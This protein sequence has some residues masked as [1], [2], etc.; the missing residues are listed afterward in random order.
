M[1]PELT[2]IVDWFFRILMVL[3]SVVFGLLMGRFKKLEET[4]EK[5]SGLITNLSID[6]PTKYVSKPDFERALDGLFTTLRRIEDKV[7]ELAKRTVNL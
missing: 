6:L 4:D 7:D 3:I 5:L 2:A 1:A